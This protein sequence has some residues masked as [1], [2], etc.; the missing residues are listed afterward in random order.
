[1]LSCQSNST[2]REVWKTLNYF[3]DSNFWA[4]KTLTSIRVH[5][6]QLPSPKKLCEFYEKSINVKSALVLYWMNSK[7]LSKAPFTV[8]KKRINGIIWE[9][10]LATCLQKTIKHAFNCVQ[11][12]YRVIKMIDIW[13]FYRINFFAVSVSFDLAKF[14][15]ITYAKNIKS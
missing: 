7:D 15:S 11:F 14:R 2:S 1:M 12:D 13:Y 4:F 9:T 8:K 3:L 6:N 5:H 10:F